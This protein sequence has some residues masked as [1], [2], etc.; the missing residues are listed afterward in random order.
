[1]H[2][3]SCSGVEAEGLRQ[4]PGEQWGDPDGGGIGQRWQLQEE[5]LI[6]DWSGGRKGVEDLKKSRR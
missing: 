6:R 4:G 1:M 2:L 3:V 5:R